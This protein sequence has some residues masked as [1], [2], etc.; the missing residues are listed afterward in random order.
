[1]QIAIV[2]ENANPLNDDH[3]Q[4]THVAQLSAALCDLGHE[5]IVYTRREDPVTADRISADDGYQVV[6]VPAGP[7]RRL[8]ENE[9][10]PHL[11][12]FARFLDTRWQL[13]PPNVVHTHHWTSGLAA[14]IG[15]RRGQFPVV[16]SY[17][18]LGGRSTEQRVD[19]EKLVARRA[20]WVVASSSQEATEL[21]RL[22]VRRARVSV[23]PSGVDVQHFH[24]DGP[25]ARRGLLRR[26]VAVGEYVR[27]NGFADIITTLS[28]MYDV[29]LVIAGEDPKSSVVA[30]E[31]R[32]FADELGVLNRVV[33]AGAVPRAHMPALLRSADI[34]VCAPWS[35]PFGVVALEA[36]A[37]GVPVV[38][39][40]VGALEDVV[41][42][43]V[44]GVHVP[45]REPRV[46][47]RTLRQLLADNLMREEFGIA[48]RDRVLA[49]HS[50]D[51]LANEALA[52]YERLGQPATW[53]GV[54]QRTG[55]ENR[56][57]GST[58]V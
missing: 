46:L 55:A 30:D 57:C 18:A 2:S 44:T 17:N 27:H 12:E 10:V 56:G 3:G 37:C 50:R 49:R 11:G 54:Q 28:T 33:S 26:L 40:A 8:P 36:M 6:Q 52:V 29:E 32:E 23:V 5:V 15:A 22:G 41:V 13:R 53:Q 38:A 47:A 31:L 39:T 7:A 4:G 14:V 24:P 42:H 34:V 19:A 51:R 20:S 1:M 58:L 9:V 21:W 25:V 48:A 16:H 35:D 45:P 43:N